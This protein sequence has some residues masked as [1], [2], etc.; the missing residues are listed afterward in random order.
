MTGMTNK[1]K[2]L[3]LSVCLMLVANCG[4]G[5]ADA[6]RGA[7]KDAFNSKPMSTARAA[8]T[9]TLLNDGRLL[10][11][12]G[13]GDDG[14]STAA[15]EIFDPRSGEIMTTDSLN[16]A[17]AGH[18][19]TLLANGK[20]LIAG[21]YDGDYLN[22]TEIFDPV[23]GKFTHGEKLTMP[24]SEHTATTLADGSVL[25][26]GGV[27]T[28]WTFLA[29]SEIYSPATGKFAASGKMTT[30][31]ESHTATLLR[32][33][34]VLITG[35][36]KDRRSAMTV[37]TSTEIYNPKS[38][39][40]SAGSSMTIKRHK[41]A[42]T[43]LPDGNVL[44]VAGSDERDME[45]AYDS[46]EMYDVRTGRFSSVGKLRS[47]RYKLNASVMTLKNGKVLISGGSDTAELFDP[48]TGVSTLLKG[49][50]GSTRL[51]STATL[52]ND[53][54]VAVVGGYDLMRKV[55]SNLWLVDPAKETT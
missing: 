46:V 15:V 41:H 4:A 33:G 55:A 36:H 38:K 37:Y 2:M 1:T 31:R 54:S 17:R 29:D 6:E 20:V 21:G 49:S 12:G 16:A 52:L 19:A 8:H 43:L 30:P 23:S 13:F 14:R 22:S 53:G 44:I 42:A 32:D 9:A 48:T 26:V 10:I 3:V 28:G 24:R 50:F 35:G 51:F 5:I 47:D 40:F 18:T 7:W 11:V 45:G 25:L 34:R 27:G 39:T